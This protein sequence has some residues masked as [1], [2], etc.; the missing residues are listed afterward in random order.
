MMLLASDVTPA[1]A[2]LADGAIRKDVGHLEQLRSWF[3][4]PL[5][6]MEP[7]D[8]DVRSPKGL[9]TSPN[10]T[11]RGSSPSAWARN[12]EPLQVRTDHQRS[13]P[14]RRDRG[15]QVRRVGHRDPDRGDHSA[16]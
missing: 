11:R 4:R 8:A 16:R 7:P 10:G 15:W 6:E 12:R 5:R 13:T 3:G 2:G 14:S 1:P 9:R